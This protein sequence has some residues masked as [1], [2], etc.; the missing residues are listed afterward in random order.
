M[1]S[2]VRGSRY[3][4]VVAKLVHPNHVDEKLYAVKPAKWK[5]RI[6]RQIHTA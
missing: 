3:V 2:E 5:T 1:V 6:L 4:N